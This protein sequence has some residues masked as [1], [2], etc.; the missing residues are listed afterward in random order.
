MLRLAKVSPGDYVVDLGAGDGKI[1][2]AAARQFGARALGIEYNPQMVRFAECMVQVEGAGGRARVVEGDIFKEDFS[3]ADVL[4]MYLLPQ[5][6]L[7]I[8]HRV[9]AMRPGVRVV[10]H[11][12]TM[13]NWEADETLVSGDHVAYLWL[14]PA[15]VAGSWTFREK[16]GPGEPFT[17]TFTQGYQNI[18]GEIALGKE[19]RLLLGASLRGDEVRFSFYDDRSNLRTFRGKVS[20][21]EIA[22]EIGVSAYVGTAWTGALQGSPGAAPWAEMESQCSHHYGK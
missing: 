7:C 21:R 3:R 22:G 1:A 20:G 2:I 16:E 14:V 15:R 4:T 10:S 9:L 6:N 17:V 5:L 13:G 19:R 8:R 18:G 12:F 11:Q